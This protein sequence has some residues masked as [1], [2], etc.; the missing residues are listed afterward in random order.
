MTKKEDQQWKEIEN[1]NKRIEGGKYERESTIQ[2]KN[3]L[4]KTIRT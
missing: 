1:N 4:K 2:D 3:S